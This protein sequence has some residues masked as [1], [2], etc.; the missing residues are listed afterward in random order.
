MRVGRSV[1]V[2][3]DDV[4][5]AAF[6]RPHHARSTR[7]S[8]RRRATS[9][10]RRRSPIPA[11]S[12]ARACSCRPRSRSARAQPV[13]ALPASAIS[14]APYG[15]SVFVVADLKDPDGQDLSRRAPAVREARPAPRRSDRG[16]SPASSAGDEVVT[17]GVFKLRNGAAVQVNN[18]VQ[19]ANNP[20]RSRRTAD[21]V[22][23]SVRQAAGARDRRQPGD[24]DRRAA[25]DPR[26]E[27]AAVPA[28]R[29]RGRHASRPPTSA[30]TP[31]SCAASSPRRSSA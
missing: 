20:R 13:I 26:A 21:E 2:T 10:C 19:P 3:A 30:P 16:R 1:R 23:R 12:C 6:D 24:P 17:S 4:G 29:H 14:Y 31:T 7:S 18:K 25:V 15:D 28:Q 27:R 9:R 8:T 22:H 11:A 5:G